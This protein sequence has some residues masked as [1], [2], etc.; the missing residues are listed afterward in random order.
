MKRKAFT[1]IELLVVIAIIA[2]LVSILLPS[3]NT[4]RE[5]AK[6]AMCQTNLNGLGKSL[7]LYESSN[8]KMPGLGADVDYTG[9]YTS[10]G[11]DSSA[12]TWGTCNANGY[13]LLVLRGY[14]SYK[15][16]ICPSTSDEAQSAWSDT[17]Y[18]GFAAA[19]TA[20]SDFNVACT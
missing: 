18:F 4:A 5:L 8:E 15:M 9:G 2:L 7:M 13:A 20:V 10:S 16:F 11:V 6:R 1:L 3:L 19:R 17:D 14:A 12:A